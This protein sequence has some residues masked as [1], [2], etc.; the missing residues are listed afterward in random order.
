MLTLVCVTQ[1]E[2]ETEFGKSGFMPPSVCNFPRTD[3]LNQ[4]GV[5][6]SVTRSFDRRTSK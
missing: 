3:P 4:S 5:M 1:V 2:N 6:N